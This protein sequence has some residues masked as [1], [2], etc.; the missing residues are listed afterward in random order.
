MDG[1]NSCSATVDTAALFEASC[2]LYILAAIEGGTH[3]LT[4][5]LIYF[6]CLHMLI[7]PQNLFSA[8]A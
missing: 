8:L 5:N 7:F 1:Y 3:V 4:Y 2:Q 6:F